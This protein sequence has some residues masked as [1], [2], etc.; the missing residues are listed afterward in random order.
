MS[1]LIDFD[2]LERSLPE[3]ADRYQRGSPFPHIVL[4]DLVPATVIDAAYREFEAIDEEAWRKYI[5][6]N[7]RKYAN[8]DATTWGP[9]LSG[10]AEAFGSDRFVAF[11]EALTGMEALEADMSLDGGGLHRTL[12]GGHLNVHADF[13][14][15]HTHQ[16]WRRQVNLL[17]YLNREWQPAWG[18]SLELW[19]ADMERCEAEV[20]PIGNR[21][22]LFTTSETA[23]HGHPEPLRCPPGV[24]RQSMALYYFSEDTDPLIRSTDYRARPGDGIKSAAIYLDKQAVHA[25][26]LLRRHTRVPEDS[27]STWLGALDRFRPGRRRSGRDLP[28]D[29]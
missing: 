3:L 4:D 25:Y 28:D 23:Y 14:A 2:R 6:V 21:I 24:A 1:E 20:A 22:L 12:A 8:T 16:S 7:E 18:G 17:L 10:L 27:V 9:V 5:H 11:L 19:S 15:H 26:D 29:S 13:T